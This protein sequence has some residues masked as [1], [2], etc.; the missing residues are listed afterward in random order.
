MLFEKHDVTR[1]KSLYI[2]LKITL[3]LKGQAGKKG[4]AT[5]LTSEP[6]LR[7]EIV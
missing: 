6:L 5:A 3:K 7:D 2:L 4:L 1:D